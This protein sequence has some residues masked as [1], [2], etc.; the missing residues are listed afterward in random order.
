MAAHSSSFGNIPSGASG[1]PEPF[2][3]HVPDS[4]LEEFRVLLRHSKVGP[5]TWE[6]SRKDGEFGVT[7]DWIAAAKDT[8][9]NEFDWRTHEAHIN[10]FPNFKI[11][12]QDAECGEFNIHFAALFSARRDATAVVFMHGWPGSFVEFLPIL[13][14]LR[15]K[16][17]PETLPF[18]AIVPSLPGYTLSSGPPLDKDFTLDDAARVLN[19]LMISLG[20]GGGYVAQGGDVGYFL[21]RIMA[22]K[23]DE[24]KALH[25]KPT[26]KSLF[27]FLGI[28]RY[29]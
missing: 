13:D 22:G 24:C 28:Y 11:P 17:T 14:I 6:N 20:F 16:Y 15:T 2:T 25:G 3:L 5:E 7:R 27:K 23:H 1:K 21:A 19:H 26:A 4:E 9:L 12:I 10:S 18:H 29:H 8:W